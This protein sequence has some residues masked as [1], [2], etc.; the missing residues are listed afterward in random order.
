MKDGLIGGGPGVALV[1]GG[2]RGIGR[3]I[4][5]ALARTGAKVHFTFRRDRRKAEET[6]GIVR[7]EGGTAEFSQLDVSEEAAVEAW[8]Q[9]VLE[10]E[11]RLDIL[12]NNAGETVDG[13]L[14][15]QEAADWRRVLAVN[16]DGTRHACRAVLR[17][18]IEQ[19]RGRIVNLASV[20]AITGLEGQTAYA[21]A[22]GGVLSFTR[23][24]AREVAP[25]GITV[26]ALVPGPVET[27]MW[28]A[29][30]EE[31]RAAVLSLVPLHRAAK[32]EEVA[33]AAVYLASEASSYVTGTALRVDGG[34]SM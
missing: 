9:S 17:P 18:M 3:A 20:S 2:S 1:T 30:T 4:V 7:E 23:S 5:R 10:Q 8:S 26:N 6:A 13:L 27:E 15:F 34:L 28:E 16:L 33:A 11:R 12:V 19:R 21:A 25:F 31:R 29:L 22:K 14:A 24:L 32:P